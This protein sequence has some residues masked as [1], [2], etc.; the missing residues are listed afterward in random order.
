MGDADITLAQIRD[1]SRL[2]GP[3]LLPT[4]V[5]VWRSPEMSTLLGSGTEV[6]A[7]L[8][9]LQ[10]T[11][12][13]KV[14]GALS[15]MLRLSP[16]DLR[17]GVTAV[18]AGNHAI[19]VAYVASIL[20]VNAKVVMVRTANPARLAAARSHGAEILLAE[21]GAAAFAMAEE[22]VA[23]EN[24]VFV[25]PFE[26]QNVTLG[27]ATLG[28]ELLEQGGALDAVLV[29][30]GGGGLASGVATAVKLMQPSCRVYGI[31]PTGAAG[32]HRSFAAGAPQKLEKVSTIADSL[33]PPLT[34]PYSFGICREQ[35]DELVTVD[36]D[37]L[38]RA[39]ALIFRS[40][41]FAVEPAC[42]AV[43]AALTGPLRSV[44]AGKRVGLVFCG[45]N[46]D[47]AT[48]SDHVRSVLQ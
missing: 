1:T 17:S 24:R 43:V 7:K 32:M 6:I 16:E 41:K 27:T 31:E 29:A 5:H 12:T 4:P 39:M 10:H 37:D 38:R 40:L 44:L 23:R 20:G 22:L 14:R 9:L 2:I 21:D 26:G 48:F 15:Q 3:Y 19:A 34:L 46:I 45:S 25:H 47:L 8:E 13:F 18:S 33:A 30:V 42:A 11:G 35:I 36:D 28:L